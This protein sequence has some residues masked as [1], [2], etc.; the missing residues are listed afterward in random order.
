MMLKVMSHSVLKIIWLTQN[1]K[2]IS[3]YNN[4]KTMFS[5]ACLKHYFNLLFRQVFPGL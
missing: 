3:S 5:N 4:F 2:I 1:S